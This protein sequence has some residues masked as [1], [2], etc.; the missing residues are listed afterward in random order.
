M[1]R[2]FQSQIKVLVCEED[3]IK[4][5]DDSQHNELNNRVL[6]S[7]KDTCEYLKSMFK[8]T[9]FKLYIGDVALVNDITWINRNQSYY[10]EFFISSMVISIHQDALNR[11][12]VTKN[13]EYQ[14][15]CE[16]FGG[17]I[18]SSFT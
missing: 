9:E 6:K 4:Y 15:L 18:L 1:N 7:Y 16:L 2:K 14:Y 8:P 13:K 10:G 11:I 17:R 12:K 3:D 5:G